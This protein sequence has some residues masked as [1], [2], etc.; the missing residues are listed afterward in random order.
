MTT[1]TYSLDD[2]C[3]LVD[4]PRRTVRYYIQIGLVDRPEGEKRGAY[5]TRLHLDQ[6]LAIR[7]WQQAGLSL[8][9]IREL[10]AEQ[11]EPGLPPAGRRPGSVEVWSRLLVAEGLEI[12]VEPGQAGL[13]PEQVREFFRAVREAY[14]EISQRQQEEKDMT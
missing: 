5:Y 12:H 9:R 11:G 6:L 13:G 3:T 4:L 10:L 14:A 8:E 2:L 7:K 1:E